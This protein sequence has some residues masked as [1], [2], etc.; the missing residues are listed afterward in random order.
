MNNYMKALLVPLILV[1]LIIVCGGCSVVSYNRA[2]YIA[3]LKSYPEYK[4]ERIETLPEFTYAK[5]SDKNLIKLKD[6]LILKIV[7][8]MVMKCQS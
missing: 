6:T 8:V 1:S 4:Y 3:I 2:E 5:S 7:L